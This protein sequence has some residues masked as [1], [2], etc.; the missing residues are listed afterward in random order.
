MEFP[1]NKQKE[2]AQS[3]Y[4]CVCTCVCA[5][6]PLCTFVLGN[7]WGINREVLRKEKYMP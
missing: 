5:T 4:A 3:I 2:E 1:F 7:F 6:Q